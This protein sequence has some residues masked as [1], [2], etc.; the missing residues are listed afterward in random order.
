M[1][2]V[3]MVNMNSVSSSN[4][5][6]A[7]P[8]TICSVNVCK[9]FSVTRERAPEYFQNADEDFT[10]QTSETDRAFDALL[11]AIQIGTRLLFVNA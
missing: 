9:R 6:K 3:F 10:K 11:T 7:D 5:S 1:V 4:H 8:S 2:T